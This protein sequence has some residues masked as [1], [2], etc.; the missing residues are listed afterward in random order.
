M[1]ANEW[2]VELDPLTACLLWTGR[3]SSNGKYGV[4]YRGQ[5]PSSA[6]KVAYEAEVGPV[7]DGMVIEHSCVRPRC[8]QPLH[9]TLV[10]KSV[11]ERL[12]NWSYRL[13]HFKRCKNGHD[14]EHERV[15]TERGFVCRSCARAFLARAA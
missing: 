13:R 8:V 9:L 1:S 11:N 10:T 4:I 15:M 3:M 7:P 2:P 12:K 14:M 5:S 6:H